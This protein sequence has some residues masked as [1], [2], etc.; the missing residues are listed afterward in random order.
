VI[1]SA[2]N[3]SENFIQ[4]DKDTSSIPTMERTIG[5][6][7]RS[8]LNGRIKVIRCFQKSRIRYGKINPTDKCAWK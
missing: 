4:K 5:M 1:K 2:Y 8:H 7:V 3:S 6:L